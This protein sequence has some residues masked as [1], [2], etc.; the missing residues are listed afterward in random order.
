[1]TE[2]DW[3]AAIEVTGG[4]SAPDGA[5]RWAYPMGAAVAVAIGLAFWGHAAF[6][7]AWT[8]VAAAVLAAVSVVFL[9]RRFDVALREQLSRP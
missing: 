2:C 4:T 9:G 8:A 6:D 7:A 1:M 3:L 5:S